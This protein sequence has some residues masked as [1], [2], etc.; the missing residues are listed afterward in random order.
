MNYLKTALKS[1]KFG[2]YHVTAILLNIDALESK[3]LHWQIQE[4]AA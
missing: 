4:V 3:G 1:E 2:E